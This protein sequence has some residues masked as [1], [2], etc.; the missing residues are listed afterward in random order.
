M[1]ASNFRSE[2]ING[3]LQ[4]FSACYND[5]KMPTS[6]AKKVSEKVKKL[7]KKHRAK[8]NFEDSFVCRNIDLQL[9]PKHGEQFTIA[10]LT[11]LHVGRVTPMEA[12]MAAVSLVN[13]SKPDLIL[14]TGDFVCHSE[15]YLDDLSSLLKKL[16]APCFAVLGNH[17]H[18]TNAQ[19]VSKA[20]KKG[21]A[22]LLLNQNTKL[23]IDHKRLQ[24]TGLDDPYT[25][26]DD[27]RKATRGLKKGLPTIGLSHIGES[28]EKLWQKNTDLVL[29]G[30]THAGQVTVA[31][32]NE[33]LLGK[34]GGH[35]YIHGL[36]PN[37]LNPQQQLYVGAG[38]GSAV[39]PIRIGEKAKREVTIFHL[40]T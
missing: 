5:G 23:E 3:F 19:A 1:P 35:K 17:D 39:I 14:I 4:D 16:N 32:V 36:Y 24:I 10:H 26:H 12:Q 38:V 28:A 30:H 7:R 6:I 31:G 22:E 18:W 20:I 21:G 40:K 15:L 37:P 13:R 29:A 33:L 8:R 34:I 2:I 9:E 27:I 11:D 25:D